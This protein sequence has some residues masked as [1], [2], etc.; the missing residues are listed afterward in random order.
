MGNLGKYRS[1]ELK[2]YQVQQQSMRRRCGSSKTHC[3]NDDYLDYPCTVAE[4]SNQSTLLADWYSRMGC[5]A[6]ERHGPGC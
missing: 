1:L 6:G 3:H 4:A 5:R 2:Y